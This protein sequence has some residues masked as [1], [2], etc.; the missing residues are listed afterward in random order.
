MTYSKVA[1]GAEGQ[2]IPPPLPPVNQFLLGMALGGRDA[3]L[4]AFHW[5]S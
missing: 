3:V 2:E 1:I 5:V 4:H